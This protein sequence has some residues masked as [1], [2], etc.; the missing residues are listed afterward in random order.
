MYKLSYSMVHD[1]KKNRNSLTDI[2]NRKIY[3]WVD[4]SVVTN[5]Y[6]CSILFNFYYRKHHCR[7]CG[8]IFCYNCSSKRIEIPYEL[9]IKPDSNLYI[10]ETDAIMPKYLPKYFIDNQK[11]RVCNDCNQKVIELNK[12]KTLIQVFDIMNFNIP[13]LL[14]L[15]CVCKQ[16]QQVSNYFLSRIREIQY[17]LSDHKYSDFDKKVLWKNRHYIMGHSRWIV[18]LLKSID[19]EDYITTK[20]KLDE[21]STLIQNCANNRVLNCWQLMCTRNCNKKLIAEDCLNLLDKSIKSKFIKKFAIKYLDSANITELTCYIPFFTHYMKYESIEESIIGEYFIN[22]CLKYADPI[23]NKIDSK[24]IIFMNEFYWQLKLGLED[25]NYTSIYKYF[26]DK[27]TDE[28]NTEV[29]NL[30]I[31]GN[32][33]IGLLKNI[34]QYSNEDTIKDYITRNI[35]K[36]NQLSIP[37]NPIMNNIEIDINH[38]ELKN[39]ASRPLRIPLKYKINNNSF[40]YN[41]LYKNE[42]IRKDKI[43][44]NI[45]KLIDIILKKEEQLDLNILTYGVRPINCSSGI[46]E[47]VP[48]CETMYHIKEKMKFS[49]LNY[50]IENNKDETIDTIRIRFMKSCAAYCV[51]TYLLGIGDRHLENIMITKSGV[52]FHIDYGFILGFDA[53]PLTSQ[54][55]ITNDMIDALGGES[56]EYYREFKYTCTVVYSC[57]R[58]HINLFINM[59]TLLAEIEPSIDNKKQFTKEIIKGEILKRFIPGEN[60]EQAE[61]QLYSH[62]DSGSKDYKYMIADYLHYQY[63]ETNISGTLYNGYDNAKNMICNVL[64][65][66]M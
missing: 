29:L 22:K 38:I 39:S 8:R 48:D 65:G 1:K 61:L 25:S 52:L 36:I 60:S 30:I 4:D 20:D 54:M 47:F 2:E 58:R 7:L 32:N 46:I 27:F 45:I 6:D 14:F 43:I 24:K 33:L 28:I 49:I 34:P 44:L 21:I 41:I 3:K 37:I 57:L 15:R 16:W 31:S 26:I 53:K 56:S 50:M 40:D 64:S 9:Q 35:T 18:Q 17:Y 10:K 51:I 62:I 55:R 66:W 63:K 23:D 12:L 42:D 59:L 13:E 19:Y 11:A 5:C